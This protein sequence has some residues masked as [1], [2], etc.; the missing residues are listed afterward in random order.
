MSAIPTYCLHRS[1]I[2]KPGYK[3]DPF[4]GLCATKVQLI[5]GNT[6]S[7]YYLLLDKGQWTKKCADRIRAKNEERGCYPYL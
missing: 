5:F 2:Y 4:R 7:I 3:A 1:P 6:K